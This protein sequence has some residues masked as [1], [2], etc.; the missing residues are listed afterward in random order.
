MTVAERIRK[1]ALGP[2]PARPEILRCWLEPLEV[3]ESAIQ[4]APTIHGWAALAPLGN[5]ERRMFLL[6]VAEA[7]EGATS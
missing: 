1:A 3:W 7:I 4:Y 5:N 6:F 2:T